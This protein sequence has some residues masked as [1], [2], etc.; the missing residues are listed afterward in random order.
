[1]D[2]AFTR[3]LEVEDARLTVQWEDLP[4]SQRLVLK[5]LAAEG[6]RGIYSEEY[7]L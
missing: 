1:M 6:D 3:V 2:E 5:A 4:R 7:R